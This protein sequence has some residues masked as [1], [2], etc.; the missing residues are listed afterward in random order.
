MDNFVGNTSLEQLSHPLSTIKRSLSQQ[1]HAE[2]QE[3]VFFNH[4]PVFTID[5]LNKWRRIC[6]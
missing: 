5:P 6:Y 3:N 1:L 4:L 2:Y